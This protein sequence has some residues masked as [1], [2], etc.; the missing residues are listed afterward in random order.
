MGI[1]ADAVKD[2]KETYLH[3]MATRTKM[4]MENGTTRGAITRKTPK[5]VATPFPPRN[6]RKTGKR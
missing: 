6:L 4:I 1:K 2:P 5:A 3:F